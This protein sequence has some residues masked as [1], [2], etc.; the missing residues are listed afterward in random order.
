M[1]VDVH[2]SILS[3]NSPWDPMLHRHDTM[4]SLPQS[5]QLNISA[6]SKSED[7]SLNSHRKYSSSCLNPSTTYPSLAQGVGFW[8]FMAHTAR[9][10]TLCLGRNAQELT[11]L[12]PS[13]VFRILYVW[14]FGTEE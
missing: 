9:G 1:F 3:R 13:V 8:P 2:F 10:S 6:S 12:R 5:A 11:D 4:P 7:V 14:G